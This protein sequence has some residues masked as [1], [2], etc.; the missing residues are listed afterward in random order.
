MKASRIESLLADIL[1]VF[2]AVALSLAVYAVVIEP[3]LAE[4]EVLH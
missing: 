1:V 4:I 2:G 3:W